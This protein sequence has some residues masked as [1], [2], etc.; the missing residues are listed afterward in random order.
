MAS[1]LTEGSPPGRVWVQCAPGDPADTQQSR[2]QGKGVV[3]GWAPSIGHGCLFCRRMGELALQADH[4]ALA[5][6]VEL[7]RFANDRLGDAA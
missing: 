1:L 4:C 7:I 2:L 5:L 3:L 6:P